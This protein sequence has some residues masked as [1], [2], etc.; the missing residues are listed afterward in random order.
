MITLIHGPAEL[1]RAEA[2]AAIQKRTGEDP[3][4]AGLNTTVLEGRSP[5]FA[6]LQF[7][8]D[9]LPF[10][11]DRRMVLVKGWLTRSLAPVKAPAGEM[12]ASTGEGAGEG[13]QTEGPPEP[14]SSSE[15]RKSLLA[16]LDKV[17]E[18]TDLVLVEE[19][20]LPSGPILKRLLTLQ[21]EKQAQIIVCA[22]PARRDLPEWIRQ[23]A[24]QRHVPLD[25][26]AIAD[27]AEFVGDD[28]RQLD[29]ELTKLGDYTRGERP[30]TRAD[31]RL[32]VPASRAANVFEMVEALGMGNSAAAGRLLRHLLDVDGDQPL[33][34]LGM[35]ARQYRQLIHVKALMARRATDADI[36]KALHT[37]DWNVGKLKNQA[38]K[39][40]L[41]LLIARLERVAAADE[42][43]KTGRLSDHEALDVLLAELAGR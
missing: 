18:S 13:S 29:S 26:T 38:D 10:L 15:F 7:A 4:L 14:G 32:L 17:P 37:Q 6:E 36:A 41:D 19:A 12:A 25:A 27:L 34:V 24:R 42:A 39:H 8:A 2:I 43:I 30:A 40:S 22:N 31:V 20:L 11:G 21:G 16:Y 9:S 35:I 5:N 3:E 33:R 23:R 28:L 1:L